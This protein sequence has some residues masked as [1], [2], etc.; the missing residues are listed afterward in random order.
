MEDS[1]GIWNPLPSMQ[2]PGGGPKA[3]GRCQVPGCTSQPESWWYQCEHGHVF[4]GYHALNRP[5]GILTDGTILPC[6]WDQTAVSI[7]YG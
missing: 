4:C 5:D 6:P 7:R 2:G 1:G 3:V